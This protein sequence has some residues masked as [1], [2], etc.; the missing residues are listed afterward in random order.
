MEA[1]ETTRKTNKMRRIKI[2]F[3]TLA[4]VFCPIDCI[5]LEA[6]QK[7]F[8]YRSVIDKVNTYNRDCYIGIGS[9]INKDQ[10]ND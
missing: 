6:A 7:Y 9:L 2:F 1:K 5:R 8:E 4:Q 10:P 3:D